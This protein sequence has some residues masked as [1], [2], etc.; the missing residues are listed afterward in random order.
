M[1][2]SPCL[3]RPH[4]FLILLSCSLC[5]SLSLCLPACPPAGSRFLP[6]PLLASALPPLDHHSPR[7][8]PVQNQ[9]A[10]RLLRPKPG[11]RHD[12]GFPPEPSHASRRDLRLPRVDFHSR[13][14]AGSGHG[15]VLCLRDALCPPPMTDGPLSF[16]V[17]RHITAWCR[18]IYCNFS[19]SWGL[20]DRRGPSKGRPSPPA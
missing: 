11:T 6:L 5:L 10:R 8:N 3:V 2:P 12:R 19:S 20:E 7:R 13:W 15:P 18:G 4:Y 9:G 14:R 16:G 17:V 1:S